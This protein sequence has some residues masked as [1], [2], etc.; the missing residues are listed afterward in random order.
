MKIPLV[1]LADYANLTADGKLNILGIF[2]AIYAP[3]FPV[4][5]PQMHLVFQ[6]IV[7]PGERGTTKQIDIKLIDADG[8]ELYGMSSTTLVGRDLP[9]DWEL[10][11]IIELHGLLFPK[12]GDFAFSILVNGDEKATAR[13]RV[14]LRES[15]DSPH[16][17]G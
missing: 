16:G 1:L 2:N 6:F 9:V 3:S 17:A 7:A 13:L 12:P 5:R 14:A 11:Q 10:P 8:K 15:A 4:L